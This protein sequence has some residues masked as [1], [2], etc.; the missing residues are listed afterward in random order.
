MPDS[1]VSFEITPQ[2]SRRNATACDPQGAA[3]VNLGGQHQ[4]TGPDDG[5]LTPIFDLKFT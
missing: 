3:A 5:G 4:R 1:R 2:P